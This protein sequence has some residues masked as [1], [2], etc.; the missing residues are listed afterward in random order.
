M[1]GLEEPLRRGDILFRIIAQ[2]AEQLFRP[3]DF[4]GDGVEEPTAEMGH[5]LRFL[6]QR[7]ARGEPPIHA[8]KR[9]PKVAK[10]RFQLL[11]APPQDRRFAGFH[12]SDSALHGALVPILR[13]GVLPETP[14]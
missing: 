6:H 14:Y 5:L 9:L 7:F 1:Q 10:L 13:N 12:V 3:L 11:D 8:R 2:D 4:V